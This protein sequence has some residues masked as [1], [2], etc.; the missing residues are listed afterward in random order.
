MIQ[1]HLHLFHARL[2][3]IIPPEVVRQLPLAQFVM[4]ALTAKDTD[5]QRYKFVT[6]GGTVI[7]VKFHQLLGILL[8]TCLKSAQLVHTVHPE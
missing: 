8:I 7:R 2:D 1:A 5:Q 6:K 4:Q 3:T